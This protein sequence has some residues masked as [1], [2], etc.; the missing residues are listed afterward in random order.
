MVGQWTRGDPRVTG[1][2]IQ[3]QGDVRALGLHVGAK[4]REIRIIAA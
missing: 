4:D 1:C 2:D 3:D